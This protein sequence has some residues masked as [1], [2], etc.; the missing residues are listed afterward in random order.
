[1]HS[2]AKGTGL[3]SGGGLDPQGT[4]RTDVRS[5]GHSLVWTFARSD[6]RSFGW[7]D[8]NSPLCSTGHP[9]LRVRCPKENRAFLLCDSTMGPFFFSP[10]PSHR[11]PWPFQKA[12]R[13][14]QRG[15]MICI[16]DR[17]FKLCVLFLGDVLGS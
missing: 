8:G 11:T 16:L 7:T 12:P 14:F 2:R 10:K 13:P 5:F 3:G 9:P 15:E 1:M 6:V 17:G 4:D